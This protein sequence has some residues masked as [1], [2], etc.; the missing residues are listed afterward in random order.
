MEK[1]LF[2]CARRADLDHAAYARHLLERHAPLALRH[3]ANLRRYAIHLVE[4]RSQGAPIVDSVN[5][6]WYE[7]L[8]AF[9]EHAYDS[10]EGE[11]AIREDQRRFLGAVHGYVT[12]ERVH[13]SVESDGAT[14]LQWLCAIRRPA[15]VT[16]E[17]FVQRWHGEQVPRLLA[18]VPSP[19]RLVT[20]VVSERLGHGHDGAP[21]WDLVAELHFAPRSGASAPGF[22]FPYAAYRTSEHVQR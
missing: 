12:R 14:P 15:D 18:M 19:L 21:D 16:H 20:N 3:H 9:H 5:A 17:A 10:P 6:L 22:A 4:E 8:A 1:L 11:R 13:R 7:S 2:F